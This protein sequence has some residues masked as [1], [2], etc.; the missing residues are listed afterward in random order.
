MNKLK[1][2]SIFY[3][4]KRALVLPYQNAECCIRDGRVS[5][6]HRI[7]H[8]DRSRKNIRRNRNCFSERLEKQEDVQ[9]LLLYFHGI[10]GRLV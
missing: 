10:P 6:P 8:P 7:Y 1:E 2:L 5:Y 3:S 9:Q 4:P